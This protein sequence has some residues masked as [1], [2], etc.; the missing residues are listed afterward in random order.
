MKTEGRD[1]VWQK[2]GIMKKIVHMQHVDLTLLARTTDEVYSLAELEGKLRTKKQLRIKYGVDVT[3]PFLHIGHA[4][5]LWMMRHFQECGHKV[6][7]LIGDFTTQ[8]GD[9]TGKS[10]TRKKISEE[11]IAKDARG[12]IKQAS[13]ILLT[14]EQVF[15]V[16]RNSEWYQKMDAAEFLGLASHVTYNKLIQR[17]MFQERI[18]QKKEIYIHEMLYPILQGYDSVMLKSDLT[19][20]GSDQLFNELM[21]RFFQERFGQKPQVVLTTKITPG[22]DGVQKQSKSLG[23]FVALTDSAAEMYGKLMSIPDALIEQYMVVYSTIPLPKV[24]E[25]AMS[26]KKKE[27]NPMEAKKRMAHAVVERYYGEKEATKAQLGFVQTFQ[28]RDFPE[29]AT[30][31][32]VNGKIILLKFLIQNNIFSSNS[33]ARRKI[34][35]GAI[36]IDGKKITEAEWLLDVLKGKSIEM[37]IGKRGFYRIVS[38]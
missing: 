16:R 29:G 20:V 18:R 5:N 9:P 14:E 38:K 22:I 12:F 33:E 26:I 11:Q 35:E 6:V 24:Q 31:L 13:K 3:A 32:F 15:E 2:R 4:V 8:I 36:H 17:D 27:A 23:N 19:I 34:K 7:L 10:E 21:G 1:G 30:E 37:K 25:A 28:K